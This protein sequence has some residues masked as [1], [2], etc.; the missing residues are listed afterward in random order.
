MGN[1]YVLRGVVSNHP[2]SEES[3]P[4]FV[5]P[6]H[7][8]PNGDLHAVLLVFSE[9]L[10]TAPQKHQSLVDRTET[11]EKYWDQKHLWLQDSRLMYMEDDD[12]MEVSFLSWTCGFPFGLRLFQLM[13]CCDGEPLRKS[14]SQP[15]QERDAFETFGLI[16]TH[17]IHN[18]TTYPPAIKLGN[19]ISWTIYIY[20]TGKH[21]I[22]IYD[23][24]IFPYNSH[25]MM[26]TYVTTGI[27]PYIYIILI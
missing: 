19:G 9:A 15:V 14:P 18:R 27:F 20:I 2:P 4:T 25:I 23:V 6:L 17:P 13:L 3:W 12:I 8:R 21:H 11:D 7:L 1:I 5:P 24:M 16:M 26:Y 22:S 10:R